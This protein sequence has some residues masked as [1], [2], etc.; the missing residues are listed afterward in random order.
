M[1]RIQRCDAALA[2]NARGPSDP[3]PAA[4]RYVWFPSAK[5]G[6]EIASPRSLGLHLVD[7]HF[8]VFL[9]VMRDSEI[10]AIE[11]RNQDARLGAKTSG[12]FGQ[13]SVMVGILL[14]E[15]IDELIAREVQ[16]PLLRVVTHI[17]NE[18]YGR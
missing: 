10:V 9:F 17:V 6:V 13:Q 7:A 18:T 8:S 1:M 14:F 16:A 3:V 11:F 5:F 4:R 2:C 12:N 15:N